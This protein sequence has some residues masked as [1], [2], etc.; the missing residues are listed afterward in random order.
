MREPLWV[1]EAVIRAIHVRQ[2]EEHGG[3]HGIRDENLL[4]S[5]IK[6]PI[7]SFHYSKISLHA[8]AAKYLTTLT[9]NHPFIDGN[10]RTAYIC[11]R[12]FLKL[13]GHDIEASSEE[14]YELMMKLAASGISPEAVEEWIEQH[15]IEASV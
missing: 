1:S 12:L 9:G 2:I 8:L 6:A 13:N 15:L 11:M 4:L 5:A 14:K 7:N 10:K 3:R